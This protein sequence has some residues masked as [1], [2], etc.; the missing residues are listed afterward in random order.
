MPVANLLAN[1]QHVQRPVPPPPRPVQHVQYNGFS[2]L[3]HDVCDASFVVSVELSYPVVVFAKQQG[4]FI[5][6]RSPRYVETLK[7]PSLLHL[8]RATICRR[9]IHF[10]ARYAG[11]R[12]CIP[13]RRLAA[14]TRFA[15]I[16]CNALSLWQARL[17]RAQCAASHYSA[18]Q[19]L[20][21]LTTVLQVPFASALQLRV[22][23]ML[24]TTMG[25]SP[26][27]RLGP[28]S[29]PHCHSR[30]PHHRTKR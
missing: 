5:R 15:A 7:C 30:H 16:A 14:R 27:P 17:R 2:V 22:Y 29:S 10:N 25:S 8:R 19:M 18:P 12:A 4:C 24:L 26:S 21:Q 11:R 9:T 20:Y 1:P 3:D 23:S 13:S 6:T 28:P